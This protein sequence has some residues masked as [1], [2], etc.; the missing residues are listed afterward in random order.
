MSRRVFYSFHFKSDCWRASMVRNMGAIEGNQPAIDNDWEQIK[1]G[2]DAAIRRWIDKQLEGRTCTVVL[3]GAETSLRRWVLHEIIESWN[4]GMGVVAVH[5][6]GLKDNAGQQST[7]GLT[8]F[9]E[10]PF[11][12]DKLSNTAKTYDPPSSASESVY[13]YIKGGL[14][15]W[16]DEAISIRSRCNLLISKAW[17]RSG[18]CISVS[19]DPK[20][21]LSKLTNIL[22]AFGWT[23]RSSDAAKQVLIARTGLSFLSWGEEV[24]VSLTKGGLG[25]D[26]NVS[27]QPTAILDWGKSAEN[28]EKVISALERELGQ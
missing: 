20:A 19:F 7:K 2:G 11:N 9:S 15:Q 17:R 26:V 18:N 5:I 1:R 12:S 10:I 22:K 13:S 23:I 4:R 8:P 16:V 3:V 24:T 6:H 28:I 25:C 14:Q 27:S 21:A